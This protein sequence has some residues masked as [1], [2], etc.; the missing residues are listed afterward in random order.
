MA[1][2]LDARI[3]LLSEQLLGLISTTSDIQLEANVQEFKN[4]L[5][6]FDTTG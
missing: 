5:S 2:F 3:R 1:Q 4:T 6:S